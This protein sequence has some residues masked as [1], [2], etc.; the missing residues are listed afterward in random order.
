MKMLCVYTRE[1]EYIQTPKHLEEKN[2]S[3]QN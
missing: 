2:T 3:P 1:L